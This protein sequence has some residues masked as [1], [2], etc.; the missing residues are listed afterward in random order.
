VDLWGRLSN[1]GQRRL[2]EHDVDDLVS[3]YLHGS[4]IDALALLDVNRTTIISHLDRRNVERRK[5]VRKM[6][7]QSVREAAKRDDAGESLKMVAARFGAR[8]GTG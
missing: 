2:S 4:S 5:D 8:Q 6:T 1:P 7:D 3:A